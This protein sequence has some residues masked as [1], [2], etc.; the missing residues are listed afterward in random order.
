MHD[1]RERELLEANNR[2]QQEAR[3]ARAALKGGYQDRVH[4]FML[5]CFGEAIAADGV[6][7]N[8]RF[9]E[10]SLELVQA[11]GCTASEAHQL[12]DYVFG[13]PVG[14][15]H[16]ETGGALVTL[17]ALCN[18]HKID[19]DIAGETELT[20]CWSKI[21]K[22]RAKQAAKPKHGPLPEIVPAAQ[23]QQ[24]GELADDAFTVLNWAKRLG[25]D[26]ERQIKEL[27][28]TFEIRLGYR[29]AEEKV[30]G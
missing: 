28:R 6:E 29:Q 23:A 27:I 16:Q 11:L 24:L 15:P 25:F 17:A 22:I 1:A 30:D 8:H 26:R 14:E 2:Y 9:L 18:A 7:R 12:V 21:E 4:S 3:D 5:A 20:R 13:R 10:E 19:M